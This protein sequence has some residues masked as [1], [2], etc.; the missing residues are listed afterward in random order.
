ML[1]GIGGLG[2]PARPDAD[3][4]GRALL[5]LVALAPLPLG[6]N[7]PWAWSLAALIVGGLLLVSLW[8][9]PAP[10]VSP[11]RLQVPLLLFALLC[12]YILLQLVP[13]PT[14]LPAPEWDLAA[15]LLGADLRR[16][17]S[18]APDKGLVAL[19]RLLLYGGVFW[20][21]LQAFRPGEAAD[22][23]MLALALVVGAYALAGV[24][25]YA[26]GNRYL[27]WFEK[28]AHQDSLS[29]TFPNRNHFATMV[30]LGLICALG[31]CA[32]RVAA[33]LARHG[34]EA[35]AA[36]LTGARLSTM[37]V[38]ATLPID[39]VALLLSRSRAGVAVSAVAA[40]VFLVGATWRLGLGRRG[41]AALFLLSTVTLGLYSGLSGEGLR[42]RLAVLAVDN[43]VDVR[44]PLFA[45]TLDAIAARPWLGSGYG[46]F[47]DAF[48]P[49]RQPPLQLHFD[50][51]HNTYLELAVELGIPMA[52]ALTLVPLLL[53]LRAA[54]AL[55]RE[56]PTLYYGW[57]AACAGLLVGLHAL[58]D[59]SLQIPAVGMLFATILGIGCA[60][61]WGRREDTSRPPVPI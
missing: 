4:V 52:V 29:G 13:L 33:A 40:T 54:S 49:Y 24:I 42:E 31:V 30:G 6:A 37:V 25:G 35:W 41:A 22:R 27:L 55:R 60:Q 5:W 38:V 58:V 7:R 14:A 10:A 18:L 43:Q 11:T 34:P 28:W 59:F 12:L 44:L 56:G 1:G 20:I 3:A 51:A 47:E 17:L 23:A 61:S 2:M 9:G 32:R 57:A 50:Y 15:R 39:I 45:Q 21:A 19:T 26:L 36:I 8:R 53:V 48:R 16:S 46:S